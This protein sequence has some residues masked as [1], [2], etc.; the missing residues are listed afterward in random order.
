[1]LV[2]SRKDNEQVI[3]THN[4]ERMTIRTYKD[5]HGKHRLAFDAPPSFTIDR[6]EIHE[7]KEAEHAAT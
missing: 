5:A 3:V 6:E 7:R 2:I 1:M 4:G